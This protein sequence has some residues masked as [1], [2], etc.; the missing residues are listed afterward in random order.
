M[1]N[2]L[3]CA[4]LLSALLALTGCATTP[5]DPDLLLEADD[6]IRLAEEAD[7]RDQAPL[8]LDEALELR[9]QAAAMIEDDEAASAFPAGRAR[10][11][12][13]APGDRSGRGR[14]GPERA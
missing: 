13:G 3:K 7:A 5:A 14:A 4:V 9:E 8:E 1:P 6:A 10:R 2:E 12:T 11:T